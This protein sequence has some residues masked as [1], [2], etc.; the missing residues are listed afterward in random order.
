M[1]DRRW[2]HGYSGQTTN[3]LIALD[4]VYR[5]DSVVLAFEAAIREKAMRV[6][7]GPLTEA[8]QTVLAVEALERE[9]NSDGY[10]GLF[11]NAPE[12]VPFIVSSLHAIGRDDVATITDRAI[13]ALGIEGQLTR[14]A[15][16]SAV[17]DED[18]DR[19]DRLAECDEA[20]Y[21]S[22]GDLAGPLFAYISAHS[23]DI[24]LP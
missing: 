6:G 18:D 5:T 14:E 2:L 23:H 7:A 15:V 10:L 12:E 21:E 13:H 8:E 4:G 11:T 22:A 24:T 16:A 17:E 1:N 19:D 9:V 20:Y 3:E